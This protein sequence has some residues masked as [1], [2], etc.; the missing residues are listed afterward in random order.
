MID[1]ESRVVRYRCGAMRVTVPL[2]RLV[3]KASGLGSEESEDV[4]L[5]EECRGAAKCPVW[6]AGRCPLDSAD[7]L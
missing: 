5:A 7:G 6:R 2:L 1:T 3:G 4:V